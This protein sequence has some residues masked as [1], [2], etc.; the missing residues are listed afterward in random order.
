M[1]LHTAGALAA[2]VTVCVCVYICYKCKT[3]FIARASKR[4]PSPP[5]PRTRPNDDDVNAVRERNALSIQACDSKTCCPA[6]CSCCSARSLPAAPD[7]YDY[8]HNYIKRT[9]AGAPPTRH[10][11]R[12]AAAPGPTASASRVFAIIM[13]SH[14]R[15]VSERAF[16][17]MLLDILK[18]M[19]YTDP[20]H[21]N[22][23]LPL[24]QWCRDA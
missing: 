15:F 18:C 13:L 8:E 17:S 11:A 3:R 10:D 6:C 16:D 24:P 12:H 9:V 4:P 20:Y 2:A 23:L 7:E 19:K 22:Y 1:H 5:P 14:H 21:F